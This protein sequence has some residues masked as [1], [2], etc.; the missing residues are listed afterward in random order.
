MKLV[1]S[2]VIVLLLMANA[3]SKA[4]VTF[5]LNSKDS[6]VFG[7]NYEF[8]CGSGFLITNPR[9]LKK[10]SFTTG[11]EKPA[12]WVSKYGSLTFNQ[13]GREF[14]AGGINEKGLV[15]V[16]TMYT[17][18]QYP[19]NDQRPV[20]SELQWIQ[21]QLDNFVSVDEVVASDSKVRISVNSVPLHFMV[22]DQAG[23][24]A[25]IEFLDGKIVCYK[26]GQLPY[27]VLGN[28][29]YGKSVEAIKSFQGFGGNQPIPANSTDVANGNFFIAANLMK[30]AGTEKGLVLPSFDILKQAGEP[31]RTQWSVIF[32]IRNAVV[33]FRSLTNPTI[34]SVS[35]RDIN[36]E[37]DQPARLAD[38]AT[39]TNPEFLNYTT[40]I[41]S[42]FVNKAYN[43]PAISWIK[44]VLP[45][46]VQDQKI[47]YPETIK[48]SGK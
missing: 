28:D 41:N 12:T 29:V 13:F 1:S 23:N 39:G 45:A 21:Y 44:E 2:I 25:V 26:G 30:K 31:K 24:V 6:L 9:G 16:Q 46:E 18:T 17:A 22:C 42:D 48:C 27:P 5:V 36:F 8:D 20:I 35:I 47:L 43:H 33:Y 11:G 3:R 7:W 15:V 40:K 34:K 14:P 37:C 10:S 19:T 32:D 4:C 38:I